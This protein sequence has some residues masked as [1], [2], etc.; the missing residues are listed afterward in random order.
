MAAM[1]IHYLSIYLSICMIFKVLHKLYDG[2]L[3]LEKYGKI[4][5]C[6]SHIP[7]MV[8]IPPI[9]DWDDRWYSYDSTVHTAWTVG[10]Q[11]P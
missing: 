1:P 2:H 10:S 4:Q 3:Q 7:V 6:T 11:Q 5:L 9:A 8:G